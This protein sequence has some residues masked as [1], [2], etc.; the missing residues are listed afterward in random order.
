MC[1]KVQSAQSNRRTIIFK[2]NADAHCLRG[3][4]R[5]LRLRLRLR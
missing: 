3:C 2:S 4:W 5:W 1:K